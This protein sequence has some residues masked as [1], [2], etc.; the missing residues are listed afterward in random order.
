MNVAAELC[1]NILGLI[2][3]HVGTGADVSFGK[4]GVN[5]GVAA[6]DFAKICGLR[7][8]DAKTIV[9]LHFGTRELRPDRSAAIIAS[10]V[11][12]VAREYV[13]VTKRH[14]DAKYRLSFMLRPVAF[15]A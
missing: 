15:T 8:I 2:G 4:R 3:I 9:A 1:T 11:D 12:V 7:E 14:L 13:D 5:A 10:I 6:E